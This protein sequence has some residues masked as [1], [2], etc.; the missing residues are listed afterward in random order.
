M[1]DHYHP[2]HPVQC[3]IPPHMVE[4]IKMRGTPKMKKM[5]TALEKSAEKFR[6]ARDRST[7]AESF[8]AAPV[9]PDGI[10]PRSNREVYDAKNGTTLP[11]TLARKEGGKASKDRV[12]N[13]AFNGAGDTYKLYLDNYARDSLDGRGM[14]LVSTVHYDEDYNN[15]F[16]NGE[17]MVYG[18]GDGIVFQPLDRFAQRYRSRIVARCGAI[19]RWVGIPRSIRRA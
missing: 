19:F 16:W 18:D 3:I 6:V 12:V 7:P 10:K 1:H 15:A 9:L 13:D 2:C 8:M 5:C 17:Q 14:K 11:G 4:S